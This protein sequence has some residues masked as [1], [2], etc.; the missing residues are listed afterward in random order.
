[1]ITASD[2]AKLTLSGDDLIK[3]RM[4]QVEQLIRDAAN[5]GDRE[6]R[7]FGEKVLTQDTFTRLGYRCEVIKPHYTVAADGDLLIIKW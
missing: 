4:G 7:V 3:Q 5:K 6:I 2:A 1:M